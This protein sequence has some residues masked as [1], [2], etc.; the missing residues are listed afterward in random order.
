LISG[1]F[2]VDD[3]LDWLPDD[4]SKRLDFSL[5]S[6]D[7]LESWLLSLYPSTEATLEFGQS[8]IVDASARY[9]GK[10]YRADAIN[11]K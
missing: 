3:F 9:V 10:T 11:G 7:V 6:L 5:P 2:Y 8:E 4:I 1:F